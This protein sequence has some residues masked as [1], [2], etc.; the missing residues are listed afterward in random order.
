MCFSLKNATDCTH[1][2]SPEWLF[3]HDLKMTIQ[4]KMEGERSQTHTENY[5]Q[6]EKAESRV[7]ETV[8]SREVGTNR[9]SN[10]NGHL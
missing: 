8:I 6:L 9:A 2:V 1:K 5:K 4:K 7:E 3:K 10:T